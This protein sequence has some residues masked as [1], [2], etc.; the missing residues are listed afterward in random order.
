MA[1]GRRHA[2]LDRRDTPRGACTD[3]GR[4]LL[5]STTS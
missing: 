5:S 4:G 1:A 2:R 3:R